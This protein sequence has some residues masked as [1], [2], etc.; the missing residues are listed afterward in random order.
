M[1]DTPKP[2]RERKRKG[3]SQISV[4]GSTHERLRIYA[5]QHGEQIRTMADSIINDYLDKH[6][7]VPDED[8]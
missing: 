1:T 4:R 3:P 5:Q 2:K 7:L 6:P 8:N